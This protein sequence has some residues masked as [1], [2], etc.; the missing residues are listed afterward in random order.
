MLRAGLRARRLLLQAVVRV[1]AG[2]PAG[3]R[4][5]DPAD[6]DRQVDLHG[7]R[8]AAWRA[9]LRRTV[10][11]RD[12]GDVTLLVPGPDGR[13]RVAV[14]LD[15]L[16]VGLELLREGTYEPHV[17]AL[18]RRRLRPGMTVLDVGAN[19]GV[20]ALHAATLVGPTGRVVAVEPDPGNAARLRLGVRL[21]ESAAPVEVVEA[22][23][24]ADDGELFLSDLGNA[25]NSGARFTH[26]DRQVLARQEHGAAPRYS[27][28]RALRWDEA[29]LDLPLDFVKIDV[30]G[31]EPHALAGM[32]ASLRRHRPMVLSELAPSN[33]AHFGGTDAAGY[34]AWWRRLGYHAAIVDADGGERPTPDEAIVAEADRRH[35]LDVLLSPAS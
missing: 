25:D 15:D 7:F 17:V 12:P 16:G 9:L 20:H 27:R 5:A 3:R 35:H 34:L 11:G 23:L 2:P 1:L 18:Y 33:L 13:S 21:L 32:Q 26:T 8:N 28:V 10:R 31:Y 22:A 29:H 30:E 19:V 4:A 24:A 14:G 6:L